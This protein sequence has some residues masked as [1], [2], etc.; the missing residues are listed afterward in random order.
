MCVAS[1]RCSTYDWTDLLVRFEKVSYFGLLTP[2][3]GC[4]LRNAEGQTS[5]LSQKL[6]SV[7]FFSDRICFRI[8]ESPPASEYMGAFLVVENVQL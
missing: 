8:V 6:L 4:H 5:H 2:N 7:L 3:I 1:L